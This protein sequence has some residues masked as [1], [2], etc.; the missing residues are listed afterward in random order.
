MGLLFGRAGRLNT[1]H[2]GFWPEQWCLEAGPES[3]VRVHANG[4]MSAHS[5]VIRVQSIVLAECVP[6]K[7]EQNWIIEVKDW[8]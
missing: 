6:G 8:C 4:I 3:D 7:A 1:K 2:A 5:E